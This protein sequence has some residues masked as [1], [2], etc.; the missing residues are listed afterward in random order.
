M[1]LG[2]DEN[3]ITSLIEPVDLIPQISNFYTFFIGKET[4][5]WI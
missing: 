5:L 4:L 3:A 2:M 1:N